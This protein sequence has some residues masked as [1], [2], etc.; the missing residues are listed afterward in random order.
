MWG[1]S[2]KISS[3][4]YLLKKTNKT[5]KCRVKIQ[6]MAYISKIKYME[7]EMEPKQIY[8]GNLESIKYIFMIKVREKKILDK[9]LT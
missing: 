6:E 3:L 1:L 8:T 5:M 9:L 2:Y 7:E 4:F